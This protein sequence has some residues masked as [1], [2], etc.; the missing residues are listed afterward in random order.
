MHNYTN[1]PQSHY[2]RGFMEHR[3]GSKLYCFGTV[4]VPFFRIRAISGIFYDHLYLTNA[5][6]IRVSAISQ[7]ISSRIFMVQFWYN[8]NAILMQFYNIFVLFS[9]SHFP[10]FSLSRFPVRM[11]PDQLSNIALTEKL[12]SVIEP[13]VLMILSEALS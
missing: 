11:A 6:Y 5:H 3:P 10:V 12:V 9:L 13:L 4:L 7:Q 8:S 2:S 1:R